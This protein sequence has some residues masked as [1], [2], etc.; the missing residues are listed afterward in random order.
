MR[1]SSNVD[2]VVRSNRDVARILRGGRITKW[3][4]VAASYAPRVAECFL[5]AANAVGV[6]ILPLAILVGLSASPAGADDLYWDVNSGS[7]GLGGSGIWNQGNVSWSHSNDGVAGPFRV[8]DNAALDTAI[9]DGAAGTVT[10]AEPISVGGISFTSSGYILSGDILTLGGASPTIA[11]T[12]GTATINSTIA[13]ANGLVKAGAGSLILTGTNTLTGDISVDAGRL[14]VGSDAALGA[15][16]NRLRMADGTTLDSSGALDINRVV[17]LDSGTISIEGTGVGSARFTGAGGLRV[18]NDVTLSNDASDFT[19]DVTIAVNGNTYFTSIGNSGEASSLGAGGT[20][21]VTALYLYSDKLHYTGD[22]DSSNRDWIFD[23]SGGTSGSIFLNNGT[24]TLTLTGNIESQIDNTRSMIFSAEKADLEL[25]GVISSTTNG[26]IGFGGGG[27]GRTITLTGANT[28]SGATVIGAANAGVAGTVTVRA[29]SL[30]NTGVASSFGT[31]DAGGITLL[32]GSVLSYTGSGANSNRAWTIGMTGQGPG[33]AILNDGTGA[34]ALSGDVVLSDVS[35]NNLTLGGDFAGVNTLSGVI[36]GTGDLIMSGAAGNVWELG[37]A[38]TRTGGIT[39]Q[40][41][42]LRAGSA[43]AFGTITDIVVNGGT[44]D[45][46]DHDQ[47]VQSLAGTGGTIALG[48]AGISINHD[49]GV[50]ETYAG[51]ITGSGGFTK[52]GAGALTLTGS[53]T[54]TGDTTIEGGTLAL[55][56][57]AG[58][59]PTSDI[60]ASTSTLNMSGGVLAIIGADGSTNSQTFGGL[61]V[62]R[63]NNKIEAT[64][65]TGGSLTINLGAITHSGGLVDFVLPGS[66]NITTSNTTLGGWATVNG[67]DY[68]KVE[69]GNIVAFTEL[70][71]TDQDNAA[72]WLDGEYIT[73]VDGYFGTVGSTVQLAG[74]RYTAPTASTVTISAGQTLGVDGAII[75]APSVGTNDQLITGGDI[76]GMAGGGGALGVQ[77]N[78]AG[79]F[80]IESRV[81]DN[82]GSVGFSKAGTG[83][84]TLTNSSNSYTG[85]T[86]VGEGTLSVASISNGGAASS[87]GAS[88]ADSSNL[89]IQGATLRYTGGTA[90]SDRGFTLGRSGAIGVG[91][92][93]ITDAASNL[94]F[95]G[96]VVSSDGAGLT[97]TGPGALTLTSSNSSYTGVTTINNGTLFVANLADGGVNSSIGASSSDSSNLVLSGGELAYTGSTVTSDR[98]FTLQNPSTISVTD[99]AATLTFSGVAAGSAGFFKDGDGTLVLS[100]NNTFRGNVV[101]NGGTLRAGSAQAFGV[102]GGARVNSGT[103]DLN[104]FD[105]AITS[106]AGAGT[107]LLGAGSLTV[108]H[109]YNSTFS[110]VIGGSGGLTKSGPG[111]QNLSGCGNN[112]TG[113][114]TIQGG[115]LSVD[116]L[117]DGGLA[118]GIGGSL[119]AAEN[120][121]FSGGGLTYRGGSVVIDRGFTLQSGVGEINVANGATTLSFS[122]DVI[123]GGALRKGGAGTLVLSGTS[124]YTGGTN[125]EAGTLRAGA[126][127]AFGTSVAAGGMFLRDTTSVI[128]DLDGF[129]TTVRYLSGGG[130]N[131]GDIDLGGGTLTIRVGNIGNEI[132]A[133]G[134]SGAGNL[135]KDGGGVQRLHGC[136]SSYTGSTTI[137]GG[138]LEVTCLG[139]GGANSSIGA[140]SA[141]AGSLVLD[142]GTLRYVGSGNSTDREFTLG[143]AGGVFDASGS[144]ALNFTSTAAVAFAGAVTPRTLTLTGTSSADNS[145]AALIADNGAGATAVT[146][147]GSGTWLLTNPASTYTGV[148]TIRGGV[149]VVDR[150]ADGGNASSIGASSGNAANLVIGN[151]STL[152]YTGS[153]DTTDRLF[154]LETGVTFIE[155]SGTGAIVFGNTAPVTLSGLGARTVGLGGTNIDFNTLGG[156]IADGA[157][158]NTTLAKNGPGTWVLTGDNTYSGNTVINDGNLI[159]GNGGTTGNAGVGNV[160]VDAPTSTL[161]LNRS[162]AF[163]FDG[164]LSGPGTLAQVGTGTT[165]LTSATNEIG[166]TTVGAGTLQVDGGLSTQSFTMTGT[167]R[168]EVNG[169]VQAAGGTP[170]TMTG[171]AGANTINVN[172]GAILH[173]NGNLG[174]GS[175]AVVLSGALNIGSGILSLGNGDDMLTLYDGAAIS[176]GEVEAGSGTDLMQVNNASALS[177]DGL[178]VGGFESLE[179]LNTGKLTLT[180]SHAYS[181]GTTISAGTLQIGNGG[182]SGSLASN[183]LN[184]GLFVFN[185]SDAYTFSGLITGSG[186][187]EQIGG[188]VTVL[189]GDNSYSGMTRVAGGALWINGDQTGAGGLTLVENGGTLGGIGTIGGNVTIESGGILAPGNSPGTLTINGDL[190]LDSGSILEFEFGEADAVGGPLNDLVVV[191]GDLVLDGI[192]NVTETAGGSFDPGL[193]RII[194]YSGALTDNGLTLGAMPAGDYLLQTSVAQQINLINTTSETLNFWDGAA[195]PVDDRIIQGGDGVWSLANTKYWA[196]D[197]GSVNAAYANSSF[198]IFTGAGGTVTVDNANGQVEASGMQFAVDGYVINGQAL[199]LGGG[200]SIIRVGDGTAD[201]VDMIAVIDANL[202]GSSELVKAD[203]GTLV[204]NGT[205]TYTGGTVIESGTLQVSSDDNLG[206]VT[207]GITFDGGILRNT[208]PFASARGITLEEGGGSFLTDADFLLSGVI[209]GTGVLT[210]T[211]AGTLTLT[212]SNTYGGGTFI[213]AGVLSVSSDGNLGNATGG[214]VF[215]GG[216]LQNTGSFA[217]ARTVTLEEGGGIFQT[218]A[219]LL[220]SNVID[221]IGTL[222]KTGAGALTLT[223]T[224]TYAGGTTISAGTLQLGGGGTSGSIAGDVL[225]NGTLVFSRSDVYRFTGLIS[226]NGAVEQAGSGTTILSG[227]NTY[228]AQT[229]VQSGELLINGDQSGA[230]GLAVVES[231]GTLGGMGTVGGNVI[232]NDGGAISPGDLGNIPGLFTINGTLTLSG[233]SGLDYHFGQANVVGGAFNDLIEAGGDLVLDGTLNVTETPGGNFNPGLY[234]II[235]YNGALTDNGLSLG[236]MPAGNYLVQTS[237]AQQV[238]LLNTTG[239]TLNFWDGPAGTANDSSIH[240]GDGTWHLPDNHWTDETGGLNGPYQSGAFAVF[241]GQAGTVIIDNANG[242]VDAAGMQFAVDGYAI[243]GQ[244]LALVGGSSIVRVGDGTSAGTG[245]TATINAELTGASGLVKADLGTLVLTGANT[246]TGGTVVEAGRLRISA[247]ENLGHESGAL[248]LDGGTLHTTADIESSRNVVLA[249]AGAFLVDQDTTLAFN[250][251]FGGVGSFIKLGDGVL[252]LAGASSYDGATTVTEGVLRAGATGAFSSSSDFSVLGTAEFDLGGFDQTVGALANAGTVRL[253]GGPGTSLRVLGDYEGNGGTLVLSAMLG[254]DGSVTDRLIVDGDT[255]GSSQLRVTNIGGGGAQTV[256]GIKVIEVGGASDGTFTLQGDYVY[257][258]DQAVVAGAY[259]YRLYQGGVNT[260][261]DGDWYLRSVLLGPGDGGPPETEQPLYQPGVPLYEAYAGSLQSFNQLG[262]LQQRTGNRLWAMSSAE[263]GGHLS[264][265]WLRI[266]AARADYEPKVSTSGT[267]YDADTWKLQVGIDTPLLESGAGR[268]VAGASIHY[269]EISSRIISVHGDGKIDSTGYGVNGTLTWHSNSGFYFDSQAQVTRYDSD[270]HSST[271]ERSLVDGNGGSGRAL[272][273]EVGQRIA[274]DGAWALTPQA[275]LAYSSVRFDKFTDSFGADVSLR[276]SRGLV[277]RF[278]LAID[279]EAEWRDEKGRVSRS[280]LYGIANLYHDFEDG[281]QVRVG[282]AHFDSENDSLRGGIGVGWSFDWVDGKYTFYGEAQTDTSLKHFG[283]SNAL[284]GTVGFRVRW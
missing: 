64:S 271:G 185:R 17:T 138:S 21:R 111:I 263:D 14:S 24:G 19:G 52:Q 147:T 109:G 10:L 261:T 132:Y 18:A 68:A 55:D 273:V 174:G 154:T 182:N 25:L 207:G 257:Q 259:A 206:D 95:S 179:K 234:R 270:L 265:I 246:Y 161:S 117:A 223:G 183:V 267:D 148:T 253:S 31:G 245:M 150:L 251:T 275:Q 50:N 82:G 63:G 228:A 203:L 152:R 201:G 160:I 244:T 32:N 122:G 33:G 74:L 199:N 120:L 190:L 47:A 264:G 29:E 80:T 181:D 144:G 110:G 274:L 96:E 231:G 153:G 149:L 77:Q 170:T 85:A 113:P 177:L 103:L 2:S 262:T 171:D 216:V 7:P 83:L 151:N 125:V 129:D 238:N 284:A 121:V 79:N 194:S 90:T 75:V 4:G 104:N 232:V 221:G 41:G 217:S 42:I 250:G 277:G 192:L 156:T 100:G 282:G 60:I 219:D 93:E 35:G 242:Q 61:N 226:G 222:V 67:T 280:H 162:D 256:D 36:S 98:G 135:T 220:L 26:A 237:I 126:A 123:G 254:G 11:V 137:N 260:P 187:L 167:S 164:V 86:I 54:Y 278:G 6:R 58:G 195:G 258:G 105:N 53:N 45:L 229:T 218:D 208:N 40:S 78:S 191:D 159:I 269:G 213:D 43:S 227:D 200:S 235:S 243:G 204:L 225:N 116:C 89:V 59:A 230:S 186:A 44:L 5:G 22:G 57:S 214:M 99:A 133:G 12:S 255:S 107:V 108:L 212:G 205:N 193:Y 166:A 141:D 173:A 56:F 72:N 128:L 136:D 124:T 112:Y 81:V 8:W 211:G 209:D 272:S 163:T 13:G 158:G 142:G 92:I 101:V 283:D 249:G 266:K 34:L 20:I 198:A 168:L 248:T 97:K 145:L 184:N 38:N 134:I 281:A 30:A 69:G 65:G 143:A 51:S 180:G 1:Q 276:R 49:A 23:Y 119:S 127:N 197:T 189:I 146:K 210:K 247:D 240:G 62:T 188:G 73:D 252:F 70:D 15:I 224:N 155:S 169:I 106:L 131:G 236:T 268:L 28:Y 91:T 16:G 94:T 279:R 37:G 202:A 27:V 175:D 87:I 130:T 140:S 139:A 46:N 172:T 9:F 178:S 3:K 241:A 76:T 165:V 66:G 215:D 239:V 176:G 88:S 84:V 196:S 48:N 157:G 115:T 118:S 39:V 71:Y 114:T 233:G 102:S